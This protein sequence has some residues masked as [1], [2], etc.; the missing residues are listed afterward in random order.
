M[1]ELE[2]KGGGKQW[3]MHRR[4]GSLCCMRET[5]A[6]LNVKYTSVI[7]NDTNFFEVLRKKRK[8]NEVRISELYF[9][10]ICYHTR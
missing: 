3:V 8:Q 10:S 6:S 7:K 4:V 2:V 1:K 5:N 9:Y